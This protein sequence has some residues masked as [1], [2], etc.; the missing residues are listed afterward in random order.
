MEKFN[1]VTWVFSGIGVAVL[2]SLSLVVKKIFFK[3]KKKSS[4]SMRQQNGRNSKNYQANGVMNIGGKH[5]K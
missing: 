2:S 1:W 5:D 3:E 4:I